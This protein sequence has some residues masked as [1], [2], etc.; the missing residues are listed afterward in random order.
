[1]VEKVV[2]WVY[3]RAWSGRLLSDQMDELQFEKFRDDIKA[4]VPEDDRVSES[5]RDI[6]DGSGI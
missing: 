2:A 5:Y 1:V 4:L 6:S 3:R